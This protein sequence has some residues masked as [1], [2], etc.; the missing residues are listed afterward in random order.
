MTDL[1]PPAGAL[2]PL[3]PPLE[4]GPAPR[5]DAGLAVTVEA[6]E[7]DGPTVFVAG[8]AASP[9]PVR[10]Y[11]DGRY[12]GQAMPEGGRWLFEAPRE[13]VPEGAAGAIQVAQA[14]PEGAVPVEAEPPSETRFAAL[15]VIAGDYGRAG[16]PSGALAGR[17][18]TNCVIVRRGDTLWRLARR[19]YGDGS[20]YRAIYE[21]NRDQIRNP[22]R[23]YPGQVL[24]IPAL[25]G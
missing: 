3:G 1:R 15:Q 25:T 16:R 12:L 22:R 17:A 23:I 5:A 4:P 19:V 9:A 11:V 21:A 10:V 13:L 20:L 7:A 8:A 18:G 24:V 14:R 2:S 6:V